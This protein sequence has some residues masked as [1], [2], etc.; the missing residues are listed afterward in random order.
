MDSEENNL[1]PEQAEKLE[2]MAEVIGNFCDTLATWQ[3]KEG[4]VS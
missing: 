3:F 2:P 4:G 1:T